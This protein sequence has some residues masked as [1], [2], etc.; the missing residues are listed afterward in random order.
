MT[1]TYKKLYSLDLINSSTGSYSFNCNVPFACNKLE[2]RS[3]YLVEMGSFGELV[4]LNPSSSFLVR[5]DLAENNIVATIGSRA[6]LNGANPDTLNVGSRYYAGSTFGNKVFTYNYP[7]L[8]EVQSSFCFDVRYSNSSDEIFNVDENA[9][10]KSKL[11]IEIT[12]I[13]VE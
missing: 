12:F 3:S 13:A 5:T 7:A 8:T 11:Y 6:V 9:V 10:S 2:F 1:R 4:P